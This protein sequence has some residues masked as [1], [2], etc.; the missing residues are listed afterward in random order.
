MAMRI[1]IMQAARLPGEWVIGWILLMM[2]YAGLLQRR[3]KKAYQARGSLLPGQE[4]MLFHPA[5]ARLL[6]DVDMA[7]MLQK[8]FEWMEYNRVENRLTHF[9]D[10]RWWTY[11]TYKLWQSRH[12]T[13][14][15]WQTVK[16]KFNQLEMM[17][18]LVSRTLQP[19]DSTKWYTLDDRVFNL[20]QGDSNLA[21][22][23]LNFSS[24]P[25]KSRPGATQNWSLTNRESQSI[26]SKKEIKAP[27]DGG[28]EKASADAAGSGADVL[29]AREPTDDTPPPDAAPPPAPDDY[30]ARWQDIYYQ[31]ALLI[32]RSSF[33]TWLRQAQYVGFADNVM[34]IAVHNSYAQEYCQHR[35][36]RNIARVVSDCTD[37][38]FAEVNLRFVIREVAQT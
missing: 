37:I 28:T 15:S 21:E 16:N 20:L 2:A 29:A 18:L 14:I 7:I 9:I 13:W 1:Q 30:A 26:K 24:P 8:I 33:D 5:L 36:Y 32:D 27:P 34:T 23:G 31:L 6:G 10:G 17:G 25:A 11:N 35:L 4:T 12:F 3:R 38:P 22:G 19:G